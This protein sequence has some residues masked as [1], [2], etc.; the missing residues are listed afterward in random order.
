MNSRH[1]A[2]ILSILVGST[3]STLRAQDTPSDEPTPAE[4]VIVQVKGG[5]L[6]HGKLIGEN[7]DSV[8]LVSPVL[9][10][11]TLPR[12]QVDSVTRN[13]PDAAALAAA[14]AEAEKAAAAAAAKKAAEEAA[15][16]K[17]P[18]KGIANVGFTYSDASSVTS[19]LNLGLNLQRKTDL[20]TFLFEAKYFYSYDNGSV[21]DNDVFVNGDETSYFSKVSPWSLFGTL[22]YQ[23]DAFEQWEH[24]LSPYAGAGYAF[25]RDDDL[26]WTGRFGAGGTW[27]YD[28]SRDF[29]PQF[30]FQTTVNWTIDKTQSIQGSAKIAPKMT[31][32]SNYILTIQTNYQ[33]RIGVDTPFSLN[34]SVLNI[35]D[36]EP[37]PEGNNNDLKVVVSL[38]YDF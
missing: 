33:L 2:L 27:E 23:W 16:P 11:I 31:Q 29:D 19:S 6:I 38:G 24:R 7:D 9:G 37:G 10:T 34:F 17:S 15:K 1:T 13:T 14:K 35:Y 12:D 5:D 25:V 21:T 26:T 28:G 18:W 36:S 8:V 20:N 3:A 22:T 30:L 32:F 4:E